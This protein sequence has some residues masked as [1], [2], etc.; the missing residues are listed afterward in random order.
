LKRPQ[1]IRAAPKEW[2]ALLQVT[3][4]FLQEQGIGDLLLYGS[5][6]MS[7][8]MKNPLRSKDLD[9]VSTQVH[10]RR[11]EALAEKLS[12]IQ[13]VQ[14][15]TTTAQTRRFDDRRMTTYAIE[16][17]V[18]GK[19]FFVEL[20]DKILDGRPSSI[21]QPYV[22]P[23]KRW[24]LSVW[25]PTREAIVALRLA[26]RQPEGITRLNALRLNNFIRENRRSL[27]FKVV[28]T[29]MRDWG[30]E[31]WVESNLIQLYQRNRLRI[32]N[33]HKMIPEIERKIRGQQAS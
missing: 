31:G 20:F 1:E 32:L 12:E 15:R 10:L 19:P 4:S 22:E 24:G 23:R 17:R 18:A 26:F 25:S 6:A 33:D 29:I 3:H 11:M 2:I 14:Y 8:Y 27:N 21:L 16:L 13:K 7:V 30:I 28:T 5:Q 9:L